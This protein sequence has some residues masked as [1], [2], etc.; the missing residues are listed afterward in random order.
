MPLTSQENKKVDDAIRSFVE[1]QIAQPFAILRE[2]GAVAEL[3]SRLMSNGLNTLVDAKL[4]DQPRGTKEKD[5]QLRFVQT[6]RVQLEITASTKYS[7]SQPP[8]ELS[9]ALDIVVL[10]ETPT[11]YLAK[12][13]PGDVI[14]QVAPESLSAA[15]EVKASPSLDKTAGGEYIKD[16]SALLWLASGSGVSAY[17]VL[18]DKS[19]AFYSPCAE[20]VANRT[21]WWEDREDSIVLRY[22][23]NKKQ[24]LGSNG[25]GSI[26]TSPQRLGIEISGSK[27][28]EGV[29]YVE[30]WLPQCDSSGEW[31]AGKMYASLSQER[32]NL[33]IDPA[34]ALKELECHAT[35]RP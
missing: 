21:R 31:S 5:G 24:I 17:F 27:P 23:K 34:K 8:N 7:L 12:N 11:L 20:N 25:A 2:R 33:H 6:N 29:R 3:R 15:I 19:D 26:N 10:S 9:K 32:A 1:D 30:I 22:R 13:G 4:I 14:Q 35:G 18:L 16:I 28:A